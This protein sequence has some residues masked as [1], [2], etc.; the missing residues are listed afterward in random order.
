[1]PASASQPA[2]ASPATVR[3]NAEAVIG[4]AG[5]PPPAGPDA[6]LKPALMAALDRLQAI[7]TPAGDPA[8]PPLRIFADG[9]SGDLARL[10]AAFGD[11]DGGRLPQPLPSGQVEAVDRLLLDGLALLEEF[12]PDWAALTRD[13]VA[14]I[15]V[16]RGVGSISASLNCQLGTVFVNPQAGWTRLDYAETLLHESIHEAHFL[17]E[18]I[19]EWYVRPFRELVDSDVLVMSPILRRLRPLPLVLQAV[20][21]GAPIVDLRWWAG[22]RAGAVELHE[23]VS[24][25]LAG[26]RERAD[27]LTERGRAVVRELGEQL[28]ASPAA[29]ANGAPGAVSGSAAVRQPIFATAAARAANLGALLAFARVEPAQG[30][31]LARK[32]ALV[33]ALDRLQATPTP[34]GP[35]GLDPHVLFVEGPRDA[36]APL[37]GELCQADDGTPGPTLALPSEQRPAIR[38]GV[39]EGLGLLDRF[40]ADHAALVRD[41]VAAIVVATGSDASNATLSS[42]L[43]TVYLNPPRRWSALDFAEALLHEAVHVAHYLDQMVRP[44]FTRPHWE[45]AGPETSVVSSIRRVPRSLPHALEACCVS[46]V[47]VELLWWADVRERAA[48]LCAS[49]RESL[50]GVARLERY[51]APRGREVADDLARIV[52]SSPA[53]AAAA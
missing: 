18:M 9:Q 1:M 16:G 34:G 48:S 13:L 52:G 4:F 38:A 22:E 10:V 29:A 53:L 43:A 37:A 36:L 19:G 21:V 8:A 50:A 6:P 45:L 5:S 25:S 46:A 17:D 26:V 12:H 2:F 24:A 11:P 44:W 28:A 27:L 3:A 47:L 49:T 42:Q 32:R 35:P 33:Q 31:R 51:L 41:L 40:D 15:V 7:P 23:R 30:E 20:C 14:A 39:A